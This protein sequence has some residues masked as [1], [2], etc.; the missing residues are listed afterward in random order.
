[1]MDIVIATG[2][3]HKFREL[4]KLLDVP[5]VRWHSLAGFPRVPP[6]RED[7]KS[8]DANAITKARAAAKITGWLALADDSGIEVNALGGAP[9][10]R[11]ARFAGAHRGDQA[12]NEKLLR[13]MKNI[14]VERRGARYRCSL[15]LASPSRV[16]AITR[17]SWTGRIATEPKGRGGFGYDPIVL[18]S[19]FG[20]T[21]A[22]L[23]A[24]VKRRLSHR[25]VA[26]RRMVLIL[27][28]L[29]ESPHCRTA[30][31]IP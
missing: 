15:V 1:M 3:R 9:G 28:R 11:S 14:P 30:S 2:N 18:I 12:N 26:A 27:K 22:Q 19:R 23:P 20:K 31:R 6:V 7:G 4:T 16:I 29:A 13:L 24:G 5:G 10:I 17:G 25:A 8:F 21:V